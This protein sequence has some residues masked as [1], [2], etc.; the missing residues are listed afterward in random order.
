MPF[1]I[2]FPNSRHRY[3]N[4]H[5]GFH[6]VKHLLSLQRLHGEEFEGYFNSWRHSK[7]I[8]A[9]IQRWLELKD[10]FN[11]K[12]DDEGWLQTM[13]KK[14]RHW[15]SCYLKDTFFAGMT[16]SQRS[17]SINAFFDT[18]VNS[19]TLLPDFVQQYDKVELCRRVEELNEDFATL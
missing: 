3:C 5:L 8:E 17:E 9:C 13:Y 2:V 7:T 18:Y 1:K 4:W 11:V 15:V 19:Q 12:E 16:S 14:R 6:V 10:K